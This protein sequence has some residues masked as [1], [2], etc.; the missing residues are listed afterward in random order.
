MCTRG[1]RGNAGVGR[2][3]SLERARKGLWE[4]FQGG[5]G[6]CVGVLAGVRGGYVSRAT[7]EGFRGGLSGGGGGGQWLEL[8][9]VSLNMRFY[10]ALL[11]AYLMF[12]PPPSRSQYS[13][14]IMRCI[15]L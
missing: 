11:L 4:C 6:G 9:W 13:V 3:L 14:L 12:Q 1:S 8:F 7:K 10:S 5:G 2:G 15:G